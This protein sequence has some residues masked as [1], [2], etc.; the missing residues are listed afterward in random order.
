MYN[1][2]HKLSYSNQVNNHKPIADV[3][4]KVTEIMAETCTITDWKALGVCSREE[5]HL[6]QLVCVIATVALKISWWDIKAKDDHIETRFFI[7]EM[8]MKA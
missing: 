2:T 7:N 3:N 1:Q 6:S 8:I 4:V 5:M